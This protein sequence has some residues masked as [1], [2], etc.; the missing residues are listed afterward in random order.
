MGYQEL[1]K[2][3]A[4]TVVGID[5][6]TKS[7]AYA[8]MENGKLKHFGEEKFTGASVYERLNSARQ[9][10]AKLVEDGLLRGDYVA[11]E[12]AILGRSTDAT[13]KLA[14]VYGAVLSVIMQNKMEVTTVA[15][16][17]WQTFL[18]NPLLKKAEKDA[19]AKDNP[20]R[21]AS[22]LKEHGRKIRKNKTMQII[23]EKYGVDAPTDNIS[24]AI[25]VADYTSHVLTRAS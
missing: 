16:I 6:S 8:V 14:Y 9:V 11:M 7:L 21:S 4:A 2:K 25:G 17:T 3:K 24:D 10:T 18:G 22:W 20:N 23:K 5:C 13:I 19:L 12:A 15:P 1:I